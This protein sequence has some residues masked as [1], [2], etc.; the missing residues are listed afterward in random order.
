MDDVEAAAGRSS[1]ELVAPADEAPVL[2]LDGTA[3]TG[4]EPA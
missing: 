1:A 2:A 4:E 3:D